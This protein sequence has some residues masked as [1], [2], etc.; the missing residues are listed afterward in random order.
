MFSAAADAV[1]LCLLDDEGNEE[2]FRLTEVERLRVA[3]LPARGPAGAALRVP[4][5]RPV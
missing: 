4:R 1:D 3:C 5:P 2:R